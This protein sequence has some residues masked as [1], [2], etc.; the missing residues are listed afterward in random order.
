MNGESPELEELD[1]LEDE[2]KKYL[3]SYL[4]YKPD[5]EKTKQLIGNLQEHF[6]ALRNEKNRTLGNLPSVKLSLLQL[7][8][9]QVQLVSHWFWLASILFFILLTFASHMIDN[10]LYSINKLFSI[11]VP[12]FFIVCFLYQYRNVNQGKR[13][14]ESVTPYPTSLI[15]LCRILL[16]LMMSVIFGLFSSLYLKLT[17]ATF[18]ILPFVLSWLVP[19]I[20]LS[21]LLAVVLFYKGGK[22][23]IFLSF[24][25]WIAQIRFSYW[26][27]SGHHLDGFAYYFAQGCLLLIGVILLLIACR[28]SNQIRMIEV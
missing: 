28:K 2:L 3:T 4:A 12:F 8:R 22:T 26:L 17:I 14:I 5:T 25:G 9:L 1:E 20:L 7:F 18:A 21:G 27:Y 13:T 19:V 6:E 23:A 16:L 10:P 15:Y 11:I 24:F